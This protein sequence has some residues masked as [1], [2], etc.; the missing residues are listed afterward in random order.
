[1]EKFRISYDNKIVEF[2]TENEAQQYKI[3][4][5]ISS[6]I[7]NFTEEIIVFSNVPETISSRQLRLALVSSGI[8]LSII[9]DTINALPEPNN[10]LTKITWEYSTIF[11][12]YHPLL[13]GL[14]LQLGLNSQQIDDLFILGAS[15]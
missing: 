4:N 14:G 2:A 6:E 15:L 13:E 5:N 8:S 1:M 7:E 3:D 9:E 12:R 10:S 11:E